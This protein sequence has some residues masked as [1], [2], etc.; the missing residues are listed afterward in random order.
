[1][2]DEKRSLTRLRKDHEKALGDLKSFQEKMGDPEYAPTESEAERI[3]A[4]VK[5]AAG[6][7][8]EIEAA[9]K[10]RKSVEGAIKGSERIP[11]PTFPD[12]EPIDPD[13]AGKLIDDAERGGRRPGSLKRLTAIDGKRAVGMMPLGTYVVASEG[14][15]EFLNRGMPNGQ[16]KLADVGSLFRAKRRI[17]RGAGEKNVFVP[18]SREQLKAFWETK[19]VPT[20]GDDVI[21]PSLDS[22]F[23]RVTEHD[24]LVLRD[25]LNVVP[26][27]S[28]AI[29]YT[30]LV[31]YTRGAS[32]VARSAQK[33]ESS[34]ELDTVTEAIRTIA[35]WI[36]VE[37]QQLSDLPA[38]AGMIN[39][40]LLYDVDKH[41][42]EQVIYGDGTGENF[43]GVMNDAAVLG[44]SRIEGGDTIIDIVRRGITDVRRAGY[45][46]NGV[47]IDPLDWES[48]V[49]EKGSDNRYVWV[50]VTDGA[51]QR[52]W[53]VPVIE[54]EAME[55][56]Q[57]NPTEARNLI[58]GDWARGATLYDRER[59]SISVGWINDQFI[60]NQRTILAEMRA[61]LAVKRPGAF[62][63]YET[64]AAVT[65]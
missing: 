53:A 40:E 41:L 31:S 13:P 64:Q 46:A 2:A 7:Q 20:L 3:D 39:G 63:T 17:G 37:E 18:V 34:M 61:V 44:I 45:S 49:L 43:T 24:Q 11:N 35:V 1:M 15:K 26:T 59:S 5:E 23:V 16:V 19:A 62:R 48:V 65:S 21:E 29:K 57:G 50:V 32:T 30:R 10:R 51:T 60:R 8:D 56:F 52:L 28:E 25:V 9:E 42:E 12:D 14:M 47:T 4:L 36:P 38:L 6:I 27:S 22:D 54:T 33:P 55:D 58:V